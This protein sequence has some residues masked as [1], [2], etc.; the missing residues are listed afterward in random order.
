MRVVKAMVVGTA[1]KRYQARRDEADV[2]RM[3]ALLERIET[4]LAG[5][6]DQPSANRDGAGDRA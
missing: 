5:L 3:E 2:R 1:L 4:H 6:T